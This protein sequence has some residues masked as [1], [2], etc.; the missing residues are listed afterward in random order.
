[1]L[2]GEPS[3]LGGSLSLGGLGVADALRIED[4]ARLF[5]GSGSLS[6]NGAVV[7]LNAAGG[8]GTTPSFLR[9]EP[10]AT[11]DVVGG[12]D[13]GRELGSFGE[14]TLGGGAE[15]ATLAVA[16][17]ANIGVFGRGRLLGLGDLEITALDGM[18]LGVFPGSDALME[19]TGEADDPDGTAHRGRD[20]DHQATRKHG[21]DDPFHAS[22][23]G[24]GSH[25]AR[26]ARR[27][28]G[29]LSL[30][31][32]NSAIN[33]STGIDVGDAGTGEL[34][35]L[36]SSALNTPQAMLGKSATGVGT[37]SIEGEES[38]LVVSGDLTV[39]ER[40]TATLSANQGD[41]SSKQAA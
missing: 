33:V 30:S 37:A 8:D 32:A 31:G 20:L 28:E 4:A 39:G 7:G 12:L 17:G 29:T 34:I 14:L 36:D 41:G 11:L 13:L 25:R 22:D 10:G 16:G 26:A 15:T 23:S 18:T 2:G 35:I 21:R 24:D 38:R 19:L 40:G 3:L 9:I 6:A 5:L 27:G 1:M